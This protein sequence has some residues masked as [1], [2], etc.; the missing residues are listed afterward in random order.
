VVGAPIP[1]EKVDPREAGQEVFNAAV[2]AVHARYC[3]ALQQLFDMH[4]DK[5]APER[6]GDLEIVG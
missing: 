6:K 5:Y 1:V 3:E 4:K 2:D